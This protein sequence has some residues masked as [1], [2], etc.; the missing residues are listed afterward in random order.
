MTHNVLKEE[1]GLIGSK[2]FCQSKKCTIENCKTTGH[3]S[4]Y[5]GGLLGKNS[6]SNQGAILIINNCMV[7]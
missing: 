7:L 5:G 4:Q 2:N 1:C 3:V 6:C